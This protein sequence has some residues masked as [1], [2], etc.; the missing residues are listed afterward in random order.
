MI[1]AV[2]HSKGG[3][4]KT[5]VALQLALY[6]K[7]ID[8]RDVWLVDSD[9]Q[10]SALTATSIRSNS[11]MEVPVLPCSSFTD[12][13][14]LMTQVQEQAKKWDDVVIDVGGRVTDTMRAAMMLCDVMVIPV[15][16]RSFD[17]WAVSKLES[18]RKSA[19]SFGA[20]FRTLVFISCADAQPGIENEIVRE[21]IEAKEGYEFLDC[22]VVRRK[23]I[24]TASGNGLSVFEFKPRDMKACAEIEA[25]A[26]AVFRDL[27]E[28]E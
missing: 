20:N 15:P 28:D 7:L 10:Q 2:A 12:G 14:T 13:S 19:M 26:K 27:G 5:T 22:Q 8:R 23:A 21:Q 6:R 1:I 9:E 16:P 25:L 11:G 24:A 4:G 18:I 17:V 3:T